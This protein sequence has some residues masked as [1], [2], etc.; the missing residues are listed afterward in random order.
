[1]ILKWKLQMLQNALLKPL[2]YF[3]AIFDKH[4]YVTHKYSQTLS[5]LMLQVMHFNLTEKQVE[6]KY[7]KGTWKEW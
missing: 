1:M 5:A 6:E 7:V 2:L 4:Y 3:A